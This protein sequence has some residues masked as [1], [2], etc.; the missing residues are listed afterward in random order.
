[1]KPFTG[2]L[3]KRNKKKLEHENPLVVG[4]QQL[5]RD[6]LSNRNVTAC[7]FAKKKEG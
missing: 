5:E 4:D 7:T 3:L 2:I 6:I 1:L